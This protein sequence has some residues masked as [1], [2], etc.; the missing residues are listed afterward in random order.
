MPRVYYRV[1]STTFLCLQF[2]TPSNFI[3]FVPT[4][5]LSLTFYS[6]YLPL[7]LTWIWN[8]AFGLEFQDSALVLPRRY[9]LPTT[10]ISINLIL[11]G[12]DNFLNHVS[13]NLHPTVPHSPPQVSVGNRTDLKFCIYRKLFINS[14]FLAYIIMVLQLQNLFIM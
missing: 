7:L 14:L 5:T 2:C 1:R 6:L 4:L 3:Y 9:Q 10:V 12:T 11:C 8:I 13:Q